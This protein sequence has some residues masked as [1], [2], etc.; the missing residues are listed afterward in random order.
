MLGCDIEAMACIS[1]WNRRRASAWAMCSLRMTL[2]A[3]IRPMRRCL[4]LK[5]RPMPPSPS[6]SRMM[7]WPRISSLPFVLEELVD[8]VG[9]Q[10]AAL[11]QLAGQGTRIG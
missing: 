5:T 6:L 7:Y 3:T 4:P 8:L 1:R 10:P 9:R 11:D 2:M